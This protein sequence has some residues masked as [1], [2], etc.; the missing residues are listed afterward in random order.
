MATHIGLESRVGARLAQFAT[1]WEAITDD[2]FVVTTLRDGYSIP[3]ATERPPLLRQ[4]RKFA[5]PA[6]EPKRAHF[7]SAVQKLADK[8][9]VE[10]VRDPESPGFYSRLFLV[11]KR[12]GG[13]RPVIDLKALNTHIEV[14]KFQM[15]TAKSISEALRPREWTT[16]LDLKDAYLHVPIAS[17]SKKYL[18]FAYK[19][20]VF[21]FRALPFGLASAPQVFTRLVQVVAAHCHKQGIRIHFYLDD[22]LIR[23][24]T[25][26]ELLRHTRSVI[27]LCRE[28]G[29]IPNLDKSNLN[30]QQIFIFLG[31]QFDLIRFLC[32]PSEDR[33]NRLQNMLSKFLARK[34]RTARQWLSLIGTLTSMDTQVPL[35]RLHRRPIQFALADRWSRSQDLAT[36]VPVLPHDREHLEWWTNRDNVMVGL[37][38]TPFKAEVT[39]FT[40][41]SKAGWGAHMG[42][43]TASGLWPDTQRSFHINWLELEAI[44]L[45]LLRFL[46]WVK[47]KHVLVMCDN[48]TALAYLNKQGGTRSKR[49]TSLAEKIVLLCSQHDIRVLGRHVPGH[50][51]VLAD[52]LSR[53]GQVIGTEWSLHPGVVQALWARWGMPHVDLF[54]TESNHKLPVYVA[55]G[56]D[57][58]ALAVDALAQSWDGMWAYAYPPTVLVPK[59][60]RKVREHTCE[61]IFIAPWWPKKEWS[62]DLLEL[63][64]EPPRRLPLWTRLLRQPRSSRFHTNPAVLNLHAWRLSHNTSGAQASRSRWHR[65]LPEANFENLL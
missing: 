44:R 53:K 21:Q 25:R 57:P 45:A 7:L 19:D 32:R 34:F 17:T 10:P 47:S 56:P 30:P 3:F 23:A 65:G 18:R 15:E 36:P 5:E 64:V 28:L 52:Q 31:I 37:S 20:K 62:L 39:M 61:L 22:W 26:L 63:S 13:W 27:E 24:L 9:A 11:P 12:D 43:R 6:L 42:E 29:L 38:L 1:K 4:P 35:G 40:D 48:R 55:P 46:P 50:Q 51:N 33:W 14:P 58:Q 16:S 49:L 41:A 8:G 59:V 54:A 2:S 60:L